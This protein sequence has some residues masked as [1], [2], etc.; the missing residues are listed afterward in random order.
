MLISKLGLSWA[1][2]SV[3][4]CVCVWGGGCYW[5][6]KPER[7]RRRKWWMKAGEPVECEKNGGR[8]WREGR[9]GGGTE[10]QDTEAER[11]LV[12]RGKKEK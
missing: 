5:T 12:G 8:G 1:G 7:G 11:E 3:C 10:K 9:G 2:G 4:V 6:E